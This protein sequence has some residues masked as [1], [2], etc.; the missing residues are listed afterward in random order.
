VH[1]NGGFLRGGIS[2]ELGFAGSASY[3]VSPRVTLSGELLARHI[4][5]LRQV[6]AVSA[7]HPTIGE[8]ETLRLMAGQ[9]GR[10]MM[11]AVTG[12]KWNVNGT[13]VIAAHIVWPLTRVGL[14]PRATPT[15]A[16]E[17]AF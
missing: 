5:K 6:V 3:A 10:T 4:E 1:G 12:V 15:I 7:D 8:V 13:L 16:F 2:N 17:Y 14:T 9:N 11:N